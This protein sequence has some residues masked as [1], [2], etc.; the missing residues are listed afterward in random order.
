VEYLL[1]CVPMAF[2]TDCMNSKSEELKHDMLKVFG[3]LIGSICA[4]YREED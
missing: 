3:N 2:L 4:T 1:Q